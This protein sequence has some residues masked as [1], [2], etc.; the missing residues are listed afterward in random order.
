MLGLVVIEGVDQRVHGFHRTSQGSEVGH[1]HTSR[2][3]IVVKAVCRRSWH[4]EVDRRG[5]KLS[6]KRRW[7]VRAHSSVHVQ[8]VGRVLLILLLRLLLLSCLLELV[9]P[10]VR[11]QV[12]ILQVETRLLEVQG[13]VYLVASRPAILLMGLT[14]SNT[15]ILLLRIMLARV[16][17]LMLL[18]LMLMLI[19]LGHTSIVHLGHIH[20]D[21][22]PGLSPG[23]LLQRRLLLLVVQ[24]RLRVRLVTRVVRIGRVSSSVLEGAVV[25]GEVEVL[26]LVVLWRDNRWGKEQDRRQGEMVSVSLIHPLESYQADREHRAVV[27]VFTASMSRHRRATVREHEAERARATPT[28]SR[29]PSGQWSSEVSV[30]V[31][32][33]ICSEMR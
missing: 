27:G 2:H 12:G 25:K 19:R 21:R 23:V 11:E 7:I 20:V 22:W 15:V 26:H 9:L 13:V 17:R 28:S 3:T 10:V 14:R 6:S 29:R 16:R 1:V 30:R 24:E 31:G 8:S 33:R 32:R 18:V 5:L 4:T